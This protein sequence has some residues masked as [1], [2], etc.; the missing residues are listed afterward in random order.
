MRLGGGARLLER[1]RDLARLLAKDAPSEGHRLALELGSPALDQ[2]R[3][4]A[5]GGLVREAIAPLIGPLSE[6]GEVVVLADQIR[7]L[8]SRRATRFI[9]FG[10]APRTICAAY[11]RYFARL[12]SSCRFSVLGSWQAVRYARRPRR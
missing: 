6:E 2:H 3:Q 10:A 8:V 9:F 11:Q 7:Q 5:G 12:R 4:L 1:P